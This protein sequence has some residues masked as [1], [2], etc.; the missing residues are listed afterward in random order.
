MKKNIYVTKPA[1]PS[2]FRF[3]AGILSIWKNKTLTN[4][5]PQ[6]KFFERELSDF[7]DNDLHVLTT[8]NGTEALTIAI[9]ALGI[10]NSEILTSPYSFVATTDAI[11]LTHNIPKFVDIDKE[12][13]IPS[14]KQLEENIS[15][16]TK[17]VLLTQVYGLPVDLSRI[18]KICNNKGIPLII[19]GAHSF[20]TKLKDGS[21]ILSFGT[22]STLSFH[23]T[24]VLSSFEG[25]AIITKDSRIIN[26]SRL[27]ANFGIENEET[28]SEI[29]TNAKMSEVHALFGRLNLE[30]V[31]YYIKK[32]MR[33][34]SLYNQLLRKDFIEI[35]VPINDDNYNYSYFPIRIINSTNN[36]RLR[37]QI[38]HE[39][40]KE[41]IY[42]R[43]YFGISLNRL[44]FIE[45]QQSCPVSELVSDTI[46]SLPI[47]PSL[48]SSEAKRVCS[49]IN[50][51]I[52]NFK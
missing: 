20:G 1:M 6:V 47:Y 51:T 3:V 32:R 4:F 38:Q 34:A 46:L 39:L 43:K 52:E 31:G 14:P 2:F 49:I 26:K 16:K 44:G 27:I 8:N 17:A 23:A 19:D 48:K 11:L 12:T 33:L 22:I 37:D 10:T 13:F 9:R 15:N 40:R 24:K 35:I 29:G 36:H 28:I 50:E 41:N 25:G 45:N 21:S 30:R 7:L 5:G 18:E 42:S